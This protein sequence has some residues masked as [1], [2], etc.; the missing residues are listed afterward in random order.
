MDLDEQAAALPTTAGVYIF[1]D[2]AGEVLYVGK[3]VNLRARVKQYL[4]G[5]DERFMVRYLVAAARSIEALPVH[6]EKEAL[7][8]ENQLIKQHQ[9]RYNAKL[10]DDKNFLHLRVDPR[11][12]W[13]RF[14]LVRRIK[15]DGAKYFGPY[16]SATNA[17]RTLAFLGRAFPLRTCTDQVL[18]TRK[19]PCL[20]HQM[21]R[22]IAPCVDL[23]TPDEYGD[24]LQDAMLFLA[25]KDR[26]LLGRL[27][28]R[29]GELADAERYED[30]IRVRDLIATLRS[31]LS[32]Q[33][34]VDVRLGDRDVWALFREGDRGAVAVLPV[35]AGHMQ[36]PAVSIFAGEIAPDEELLSTFVNDWYDAEIPPE[37]LLPTELPDQAA[38]QDLLTERRKAKVTLAV[39]KRGEKVRVLEIAEQAAKARFETTHSQDERIA[40]AL[41]A[42]AEIA[43]LEVPPYRI[44]CY[45]NSNLL[46]QEPVASQVVFIEGRP[47]RAEYRRYKVK[48]VVGAD[49]FATMREILGRRLRRASE[50]GNFPDLIVVDGGRGQLNA[51]E[52]VL[53]E[54]GLE[55]QPVIGLAKPRTERARGDR[56]AVDKIILRDQPD[57]VVLAET[58][59]TLRLLQHIRDEAHKTAIGF[60][61][62]RRSKSHLTSQLDS[63]QGIGP[64]R[65][66]ALLKHFGSMK[67]LK[68]ADA[69]AIAEVQGIGKAM[70]ERVWASLHPP[71]GSQ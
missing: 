27:E 37:I 54:L 31:S 3:A 56:D 33:S 66:Q 60:H 48:T 58:H 40:H 62:E 51:A 10:R 42:L 69:A 15:E 55:H 17:R 4:Q 50:D 8:L 52:D 7:I 43:G 12:R 21:H 20:L 35:R 49:D 22:C 46:G 23:C 39:P 14:T 9:P 59:P 67:A 19:R 6:T 28:R 70:A 32:Q 24:T 18:A 36:Q 63:L 65:R 61:R 13:P 53:R 11:S 41:D 16:A 38:L 44:E 29:M 57:P 30:A 68:A 25:G 26:E 5:H 71:E 45:D 64:T 34:V 47:A 1:R 2:R